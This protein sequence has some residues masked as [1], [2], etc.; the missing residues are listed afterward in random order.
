MLIPDQVFKI[1]WSG[2]SIKH[3]QNKGYEFTKRLDEFE[4]NLIDLSHSS[5][6]KIKIQCDYCLKIIEKT[7]QNY[8]IQKEISPIN[9]D[10]CKKC[11]PLKYIETSQLKYGV[12]NP[13]LIPSIRQKAIDTNLERYGVENVL[14]SEEI[15]EKIKNYYMTNFGVNNGAQVESI[16]QKM[17]ESLFKN[18]TTAI[19]S[20]QI[21]I[22]DVAEG[23]LNYP[24]LNYSLDIAFP[25]EQVYIE[26]NGGG[27]WLSVIKGQS[28]EKEFN[29]KAIIRYKQLKKLGWKMI[30]IISKRDRLPSK[31][32]LTE[33][34][35]LAKEKLKENNWIVLDIDNGILKV[36]SE[37][38]PYV[39]KKIRRI[40]KSNMNAKEIS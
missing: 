30:E 40:D 3:Y 24:V 20:Q 31:Y 35:N 37:V 15:R 4:V 7:Y 23:V 11:Q 34:I 32:E 36:K 39:F 9:K 12:D 21:Y 33:F 2:A 28:T 5:K 1:K 10:C 17:R 18:G 29:I 26:Y 19:S 14:A 22:N 8:L 25:D 38:I 6:V 27:H 16:K 13:M